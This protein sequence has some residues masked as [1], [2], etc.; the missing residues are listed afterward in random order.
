MFVFLSHF[1]LLLI[2][3]PIPKSHLKL[4]LAA[5]ATLK[6]TCRK[7]KLVLFFLP[8]SSSSLQSHT[9]SQ[10]LSFKLPD[11]M[12]KKRKKRKKPNLQSHSMLTRIMELFFFRLSFTIHC[13]IYI[14][15]CF[16]ILT[17]M[18]LGGCVIHWKRSKLWRKIEMVLNLAL[19]FTILC[20]P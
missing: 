18:W 16:L 7:W 19:P 9:F 17:F 2:L 14:Y 5:A 12:F 8:L 20:D 3:S 13:L 11:C 6:V 1:N 4:L 10:V 15:P